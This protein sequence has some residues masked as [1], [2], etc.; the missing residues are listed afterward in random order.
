MDVNERIKNLVKDNFI[1]AVMQKIER[2]PELAKKAARYIY[3]KRT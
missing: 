3:E 2:L 1:A